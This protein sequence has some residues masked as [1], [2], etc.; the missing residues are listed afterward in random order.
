[1]LVTDVM[2]VNLKKNYG[3]ISLLLNRLSLS[4][5]L[6]RDIMLLLLLL[7]SLLFLL[8]LLRLNFFL[9][10]L[11][12]EIADKSIHD[13]QFSEGFFQFLTAL[14]DNVIFSVVA[15]AVVPNQLHLLHKI[16]RLGVAVVQQTSPD[17][18]QVHRS[19]YHCEIVQNV[20]LYWVDRL[21]E[22]I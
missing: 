5:P 6:L 17:R 7:L 4:L 13:D 2:L 9:F 10:C 12:L 21:E 14:A 15:V 20:E 19:L 3:C 18:P 22:I 16:L 1:M 8:H 11:L